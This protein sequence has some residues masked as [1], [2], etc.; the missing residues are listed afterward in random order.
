MMT[1]A[2]R[3]RGTAAMAE[4]AGHGRRHSSLVLAGLDPAIPARSAAAGIEITGTSPV[5]TRNR[6]GVRATRPGA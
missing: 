5:M 3:D 2:A 6:S 4:A 1:N